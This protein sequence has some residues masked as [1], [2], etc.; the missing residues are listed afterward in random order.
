MQN[1]PGV[2]LEHEILAKYAPGSDPSDSFYLYGM[3]A[4]FTMIDAL[5]KAGK[6][7]TREN[8]MQAAF[9]LHETNN[10]FVLPGMVIETTPDD[11]FP[12]RQMQLSRY[13][14]GKWVN[15]GALMSARK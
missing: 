3:G 15:F 1:D 6:N 14:D 2:K 8:I 13:T 10:P 12:I 4:A 7:L 11:H 5:T 9:H